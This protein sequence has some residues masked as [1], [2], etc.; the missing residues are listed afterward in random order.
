ML[1]QV[2]SILFHYNI[3]RIVSTSYYYT[4]WVSDSA[5]RHSNVKAHFRLPSSKPWSKPSLFIHCVMFNV[6][7]IGNLLSSLQQN[8][9]FF[10]FIFSSQTQRHE[11]LE[12][13]LSIQKRK[14]NLLR[15]YFVRRSFAWFISELKMASFKFWARLFWFTSRSVFTRELDH[16]IVFLAGK[17]YFPGL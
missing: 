13:N 14:N 1:W 5:Y 6:S 17:T 7:I 2:V 15:S 10:L 11:R 8:L 4:Y 3:P 16:S 12:T 9:I